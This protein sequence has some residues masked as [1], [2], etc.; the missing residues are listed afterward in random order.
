MGAQRAGRVA[1]SSDNCK[2]SGTAAPAALP[3]GRVG[4]AAPAVA[5]PAV[6][7]P[8]KDVRARGGRCFLHANALATI[9]MCAPS[10]PDA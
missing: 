8:A 3:N 4:A 7:A 9:E 10:V 6:A 2:R 1:R 5:A